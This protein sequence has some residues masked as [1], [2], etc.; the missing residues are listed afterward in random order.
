M[1]FDLKKF[2]G[3]LPPF[4]TQVEKELATLGYVPRL[5]G[6]V[7]RDFLLNQKLG[8]DW[9]IELSHPT[10]AF[11]QTAW[12][13]LGK[14]LSKLGKTVFLPYDIIRLELN[15]HE[16][17]FSPPRTEK[18]NAD[19]GHKNFEAVFDLKLPFSEA[20]KRRDF[21][22]NAMAVELKSRKEMNFL[23]PFEGLRHLREK[24]LHPCGEDF[25]KDPV[26]FLRAHRFA[27]K[28]GFEFSP[29]LKKVLGTMSLSSITPSYFWSEMQKSQKPW[30]FY[31]RFLGLAETHSELKLPTESSVLSKKEEIQAVLRDPSKHE[32]WMVALE[33]AGFSSESWQKYFS[34]SSESSRRVG[35]WAASS[36]EFARLK[37]EFFHGEFEVIREKPEFE[38]LFDWYFTT[39]QLLQKNPQLPLLQMVEEYLPEWVHLY[40]FE[41]VKDVKHVDPPYRAKYQ[42]WN[43]CQRL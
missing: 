41:P 29:E 35:R 14:I 7:V 2:E 13:E 9:D 30:Q 32:S 40:R 43:L 18:F 11:N 36:K 28:Y 25:A 8:T 6:G 33:W 39:K 21:T 31:E 24:F 12:K 42:V 10:L 38:S 20:A 19:D 17:E 22:I 15:G 4:F 3:L 23:D 5:V 26:R 1:N 34:L 27:I 37:P 16:L